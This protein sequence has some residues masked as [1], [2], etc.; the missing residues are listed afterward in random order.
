MKKSKSQK[1]ESH[2]KTN[3]KNN[4]LLWILGWLVIFPVPL[5]ILLFRNSKLKKSIQITI[6]CLSWLFY[7]I[8]GLSLNSSNND[9]KTTIHNENIKQE[10]SLKNYDDTSSLKIKETDIDIVTREGHPKYYGSVKQSHEI[11]DDVENGKIHFG[12]KVYGYNDNPIIS[13]S[14]YRNSD[15]IRQVIIN[16]SNFSEETAITVEDAIPIVASYMPYEIMDKYYEYAGSEMIM[17]NENHS[18]NFTY[19]VLSYRLT[20]EGKNS[21]HDYSG[22]IDVIIKADDNYVQDVD[23]T[24]GKPKWMNFLEKNGYH[25]EKWTLDL[26]D[27]KY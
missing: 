1:N 2:Y 10:S 7:I 4:I 21:E 16:F 26:Y 14:S 5:T 24:F 25:T 20:T 6:V 27:Y 13:M 23:I 19:Y 18:Q 3:K 22:T 15:I 8:I 9:K 17:P 11:W 12:D